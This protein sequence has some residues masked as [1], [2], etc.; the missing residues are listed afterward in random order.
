MRFAIDMHQIA[1]GDDTQ[2]YG[3]QG[4]EVS[5]LIH[6]GTELFVGNP[7]EVSPFSIRAGYSQGFVTAG[8]SVDVSFINFSFA[9]Y[10]R[11]VSSRSTA[12]E[13]RRYLASLAFGF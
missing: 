8:A 4:I 7:L 10:G 5:K 9:T 2:S 1:L 12:L 11:D 6:A 13:D 3:L